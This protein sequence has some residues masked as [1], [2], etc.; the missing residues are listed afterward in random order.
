MRY[1]VTHRTVAG[2]RYFFYVLLLSAACLEPNIASESS[3][4]D[5]PIIESTGLEIVR[6][7]AGAV[8]ARVRVDKLLQYKN[9]DKVYPE[10]VYAEFYD[11]D[12]K[13][14]AIILSANQAC[15][16]A[17]KNIYELQGDVK[18]QSCE[19]HRQLSTEALYLDLNH[20]EVF[21]EKFTNIAT[22]KELLTGS[23][24]R[25]KQDLSQYSVLALQGFVSMASMA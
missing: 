9:G 20:E 12:K 14:M 21:T 10:G 17:E 16:H 18:I 1:V 6:S 15:Y 5:G 11:T 19:G 4:Y 3:R 25:A 2:S 22:D 13:S 7:D 23:E 24:L 8:A